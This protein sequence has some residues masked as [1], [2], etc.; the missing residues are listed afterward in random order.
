[1]SNNNYKLMNYNNQ[2]NYYLITIIS[3][4]KGHLK[5]LKGLQ[6]TDDHFAI[7]NKINANALPTVSP[8]TPP[9][10]PLSSSAPHHTRIEASALMLPSLVVQHVF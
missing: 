5:G 3:G 8:P 10:P 2:N 9:S 6:C 7:S 4:L 1:M